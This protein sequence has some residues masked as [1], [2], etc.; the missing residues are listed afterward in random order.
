MSKNL[1]RFGAPGIV[2]PSRKGFRQSSPWLTPR[3]CFSQR[4]QPQRRQHG[5]FRCNIHERGSTVN[6]SLC[7]R[8][9]CYYT[10]RGP[11]SSNRTSKTVAFVIQVLGLSFHHAMH[12]ITAP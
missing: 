11:D 3:E 8:C 10:R 1:V 2:S 7:I 9:A 6:E 5:S 12:A 4:N